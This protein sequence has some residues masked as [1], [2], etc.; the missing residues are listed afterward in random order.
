MQWDSPPDAP[1]SIVS[2]MA[3]RLSQDTLQDI[4]ELLLR[5]R[6]VGRLV[7]RRIWSHGP[8]GLHSRNIESIT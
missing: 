5:N 8:I 6:K 4:A 7:V 3:A 2:T 1:H